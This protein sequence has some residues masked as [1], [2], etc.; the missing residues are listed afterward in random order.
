M[1]EL[2]DQAAEIYLSSKEKMNNAEY[3]LFTVNKEYFNKKIIRVFEQEIRGRKNP[4]TCCDNYSIP[5]AIIELGEKAI[6]H[7]NTNKY[8]ASSIE[9][10]VE[11]NYNGKVCVSVR[12]E[13]FYRSELDSSF[14]ITFPINEEKFEEHI[15]KLKIE[16]EQ[17]EADLLKKQQEKDKQQETYEK[18]LLEEL[19]KKFNKELK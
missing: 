19:A 16:A 7:L 12:I 18:E 13:S 4:T 8:P 11:E 2:I 6:D 3:V 17:R 14:G 1:N 10:N 9:W 5:F 15:Q